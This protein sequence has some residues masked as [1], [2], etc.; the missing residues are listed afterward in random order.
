MISRESIIRGPGRV[1][2]NSISF[3]SKDDFNVGLTVKTF[4]VATSAHGGVD[5]R[6]DDFEAKLSF[7][8]D[9]RLTNALIAV[10]WPYASS[11]PGSRLMSNTDKALTIHTAESHLH[12]MLA[13]GLTKMPDLILGAT[14]TAVGQVE[15]TGLRANGEDVA[16]ADK[17]Y[18]AATSGG[19]FTDSAFAPSGIITQPY[20][21][22]FTGVTGLTSFES[23][24]GFRINFETDWEPE[25]VDSSGT[26]NYRLKDVRC[27]VRFKPVGP[28]ADH[29]LD[30]LRIQGTGAGRGKTR[31]SGVDLTITGQDTTTIFVL[32]NANLNQGQF[33]FGPGVLRTGEVEMIANR[34]F[35]AG[36]PGALW[37][38]AVAS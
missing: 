1:V 27:R 9:G 19:T 34:G 11:L 31:N 16:T 32:K 33:G 2:F 6:D 35:S 26:L 23:E 15:F 20:T 4:R 7:T 30:A 18:T 38:F 13:A 10:L 3:F 28:T 22:V 37:T 24:D 12:T 29:I 17:V 25:K 36:V 14:Q 8:P 5:E 21:A